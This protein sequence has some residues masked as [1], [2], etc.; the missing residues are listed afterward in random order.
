RVTFHSAN[1]P[2]S[3]L[4]AASFPILPMHY[5]IPHRD[6]EEASSLYRADGSYPAEV[7][8]SRDDPFNLGRDTFGSGPYQGRGMGLRYDFR[9]E[10]ATLFAHKG[11]LTTGEDVQRYVVK[12]ISDRDAAIAALKAGEIQLL[13]STYEVA[14]RRQEIED[15]PGLKVELFPRLS[16]QVMGFNFNNPNLAI[17]EVRQ[18]IDLAIPRQM[19]IDQTLDGLGVLN[20]AFTPVAS[21]FFDPAFGAG[22]VFGPTFDPARARQILFDAGYT[23]IVV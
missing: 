22:G 23:T 8:P 13:H 7:L 20:S 11:S 4:T 5:W 15:F 16:M 21:P 19:I 14:D 2:V 9:E 12:V 3:F 6:S 1:P 18:A 10:A 17:R